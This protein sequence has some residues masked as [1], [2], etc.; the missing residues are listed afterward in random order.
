MASLPLSSL[1]RVGVWCQGRNECGRVTGAD[2]IH[3]GEVLARY[4]MFTSID[5]WGGRTYVHIDAKASGGV[6][7]L[8]SHRCGG[9]GRAS[10]LCSYR[11]I[12]LGM[13]P[14]PK[15]T[16]FDRPR[17]GIPTYVHI[18]AKTSGGVA[19][20]CS[21]RLIGLRR[22]HLPMFTSMRRPLEGIPTYVHIDPQASGG[23]LSSAGRSFMSSSGAFGPPSAYS[24][25][26]SSLRTSS[27]L[28]S[29][30]CSIPTVTSAM[31]QPGHSPGS[32]GFPFQHNE[33]RLPEVRLTL[34]E[35]TGREDAG[36]RKVVSG[37]RTGDRGTA[38][39]GG[40]FPRGPMCLE[41]RRLMRGRHGTNLDPL[42]ES[43][44]LA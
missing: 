1:Y 39:S 35:L 34:S 2:G 13:G 23:W 20:L 10:A 44:P 4:P 16:S 43:S 33:S 32:G 17:K 19:Y 26:R 24:M 41:S 15:F 5:S 12:G 14:L 31:K 11:L 27:M 9:L 6:A 21:C 18:D 22:G 28:A 37:S 42:V 40:H 8:C 38:M 36:K 30:S 7:Y 29:R 3:S 25:L